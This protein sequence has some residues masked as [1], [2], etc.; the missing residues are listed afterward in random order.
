MLIMNYFNIS[1]NISKSGKQ[2]FTLFI[3]KIIILFF[4]FSFQ[5]CNELVEVQSPNSEEFI[6]SLEGSIKTFKN[7]SLKNPSIARLYGSDFTIYLTN[8]ADQYIEDT[9]FLSS[10][11]NVESLF[12]ISEQ[13]NLQLLESVDENYEVL[14]VYK[15]PEEQLIYAFQP[16]IQEAK[17]YLYCLGFTDAE[18]SDELEGHDEANLVLAVMALIDAENQGNSQN[19]IN[20][21]DL[22]GESLDDNDWYD[23]MLRSVGI[24]AVIE[25][26]NGKVTKAIAKQA[27]KKVVSR[28]LG[29]V[30]AAIALYEYGNCMGWY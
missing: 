19:F 12:N 23:C 24:D 30:G 14:G 27:I 25:L 18:I 26:V 15:I 20:Y 16:S 13:Y 29:W 17:D 8:E 4:T 28:T 22:F 6:N 2:M 10:I 9:D 5:G 1:C 7:I 21:D 11:Y 3:G